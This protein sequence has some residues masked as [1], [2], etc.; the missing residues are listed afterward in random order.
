MA[1]SSAADEEYDYVI[2]GAGSSGCALAARLAD[3][4]RRSVA[5]LEAGK[6]QWPRIT[7][8]PAAL[9]HT[10]GNPKYDWQYVSEPDPTRLGRFEPWPRGLGP[11]GS[12]LI[13]GMIFVRGAP[14]DYD[15]WRDLGA[16]G[17]GYHDVLPYFRRF[18][19][20]GIGE[21]QVRGQLGPQAVSPLRYIHPTTRLFIEAAVAAGIPF[22]SDY[23]GAEQDGVGYVQ[24]TQQNGRRHSPFD[25]FL[26]PAVDKGWVRLIQEARARRILFEGTSAK[27]VEF[28]RDGQIAVVRARKMIVLSGGSIN[29]PQLLMLSG[30]GPAADLKRV[31]LTPLVDHPEVGANLIDH[32]GVWLRAQVDLDT[33][34]QD[35]T[36]FRKA[37][38]LLR[39]L[40]GRGPAT[41]ATAQAVAFTRTRPGLGAPDVQVHFTA[42]GFT[43]PGETDPKERLIMVVPS[44]NH[45]ESRGAISLKSADPLDAPRISPRLLEAEADMATLRRGVRLCADILSIA[46][47]APHVRRLMEPPP[48]END[49][50][51][52]DYIRA[53]ASPLY[54]AVGTCRMGSDDRAVVDPRLRVRGV[55]NLAVADASIMPRH[56]SGNTHAAA[57]M[58]GERA[59]ELLKD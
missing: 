22:T 45:P 4:G 25:S 53:S 18:E 26:R 49:A 32:P 50:E 36:T 37:L 28:E 41:T 19:R 57:M 42:F 56:I 23:N 7:A 48:L 34:N 5:V 58:I 30:I 6:A 55:Q 29:S 24:A 13:N 39:W 52:D 43:G 12:G 2:V 51:L 20:S 54:H 31:G 1:E 59:A 46:P 21:D 47:L 11:G 16:S 15:A 40:G 3:Q 33:L 14:G 10:I 44:V 27:G 35:A 17:W 8:I 38:A 9:V